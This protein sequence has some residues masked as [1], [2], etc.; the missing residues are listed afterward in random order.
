MCLEVLH[1]YLLILLILWPLAVWNQTM[2]PSS[3][4][5]DLYPAHIWR[6]EWNNVPALYQSWGNS[7]KAL[8]TCRCSHLA[9]ETCKHDS[10]SWL[11]LP[12]RTLDLFMVFRFH[13]QMNPGKRFHQGCQSRCKCT[14]A[15]EML[16]IRAPATVCTGYLLYL[17]GMSEHR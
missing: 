14:E 2:F 7:S 12:Q 4:L 5:S 16:T 10:T 11:Y 8:A 15:I 9:Y 3:I 13:R 1:T 6:A 17:P